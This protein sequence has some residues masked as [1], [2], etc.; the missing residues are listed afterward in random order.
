MNRDE[1]A[2]Q[3]RLTWKK[4]LGIE[5]LNDTDFFDEGGHS[6][7]A[8]QIIADLD[9]AYGTSLPLRTIYE[10]WVFAD[11]VAAMLDEMNA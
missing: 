5:I 11:F 10:N 7:L 9:E 1:V 3:A 6:F 4:A 2:D 8:L